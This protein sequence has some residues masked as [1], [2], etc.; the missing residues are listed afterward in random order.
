MKETRLAIRYARALYELAAEQNLE[1]KVRIDMETVS[2]VCTSNREFRRMLVNPVI[3][4][5]KK[6][7][8]IKEVFTNHLEKLSISFLLLIAKKRREVFIHE[9][10]LSY[11]ELY[12]ENKGIM[13]AIV[14]TASGMDADAKNKI[15]KLLENSTKSKIELVEKINAKLIGGFKLIFD[16]RQYDSSILSE[17]QKLKK[18]FNVNVYEKG[19]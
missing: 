17:I 8:I 4:S 13:T 5:P 15:I 18:E 7:S 6:E 16:N 14:E 12:K 9:I 11:V 2:E 1:D 3:N 19:F 10:A